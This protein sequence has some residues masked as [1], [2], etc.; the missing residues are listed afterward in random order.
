VDSIQLRV[1]QVKHLH[2]QARVG[3]LGA[4]VSALVLPVALWSVTPGWLLFSWVAG[5]FCVQLS[6]NRLLWSFPD[7]SDRDEEVSNWGSRF[8][9]L[10]V[11]SATLWGAAGV[12]LFPSGSPM[13]QFLLALFLAGI[14][15]AASVVYS[16]LKECYVPTILVEILPLSARCFYEYDFLHMIMGLVMIIF[17]LVLLETGRQVHNITSE[18]LRL[19]FEKNDLI[20]SLVRQKTVAEELN[21][22][23]RTEV[24]ERTRAEEAHRVSEERLALA[25]TGADLGLWDHDL[26]TDLAYYDRRWAEMLGHSCEEIRPDIS[27]WLTRIHPD[28]L[29]SVRQALDSHLEGLTS[30]YE[31]EHRL[32]TGTGDWKW[33]LSRGK[34]V[35]R[36][37]NGT[38]LRMTGTH[39]DI[40]EAKQAQEKMRASL[41]EKEVLLREIHHRVKNNLQVMSSLLSLQ[42]RHV[43][44]GPSRLGFLDTENRVR[45]MA[46]VHEQLYQAGNMAKLEVAEYISRLLRHLAAS[47]GDVS[48]GVAWDTDV[49]AVSFEVNTAVPLGFIITELVS[50]CLKHAFPGHRKGVV[51]VSLKK[52]ES[53]RLELVVADNGVGVPSGIDFNR[54]QSLGL[55]L[56]KIFVDQLGGEIEAKG[57]D[58]TSVKVTFGM[59]EAA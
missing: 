44:D 14:A 12:F 35:Q 31:S 45:S 56:V 30:L 20:E 46:L 19:R 53:D 54:T 38:P 7:G 52:T 51:R 4:Q 42:R 57:D 26:K 55:R 49:E 27:S 37:S 5:Y 6:R 23:L 58:G 10:T 28:D 48:D 13:H 3:A 9:A 36:G 2:A 41:E 59:S 34:V 15:A 21:Q 16:P 8:S 50:N 47:F 1:A 39:L 25:L 22:H 33:V 43:T 11:L 17:C 32:R 29:V 24:E 18:S 40:T